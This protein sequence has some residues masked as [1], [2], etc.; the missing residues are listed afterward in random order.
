M[1]WRW[2]GEILIFAAGAANAPM[3]FD[4]KYELL[5]KAGAELIKVN[6]SW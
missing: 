6:I 4:Q 3:L 2:S 1:A 5:K